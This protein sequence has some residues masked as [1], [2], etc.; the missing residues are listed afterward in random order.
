MCDYVVYLKR[1]FVA[2]TTWTCSVRHNHRCKR[3]R[4]NGR[5]LRGW[6]R[7]NSR[8][9]G[10][11]SGVGSVRDLVRDVVVLI[12][13][14]VAVS[15]QLWGLSWSIQHKIGKPLPKSQLT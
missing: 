8:S 6:F 12:P 2:Y 3:S 10:L 15:K 9:A 7:R 4:L 14:S 13:K 1:K 5:G 11:H